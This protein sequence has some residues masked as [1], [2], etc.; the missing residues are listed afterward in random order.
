[1]FRI[2]FPPEFGDFQ[3]CWTPS[4]FSIYYAIILKGMLKVALARIQTV[5][6]QIVNMCLLCMP[7]ICMPTDAYALKLMRCFLQRIETKSASKRKSTMK[8]SWSTTMEIKKQ[9]AF[10]LGQIQNCPED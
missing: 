2:E 5:P 1:M 9:L 6:L 8:H 4:E 3:I 10:L 7:R